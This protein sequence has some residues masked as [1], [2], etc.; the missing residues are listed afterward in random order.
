MKLFDINL[1]PPYFTD[2]QIDDS[3]Q[4]ANVLKLN[5][6]ELPKL[7][8]QYALTGDSK[9]II[10][11]LAARFDLT[12]I[13]YT[14]GPEGAMLYHQGEVSQCASKP[15]DIVDTVGAGDA[16]TAAMVLGIVAG[17]GLDEVNR[18]AIEIPS[19]VC[20]QPG[21]TMAFPADFLF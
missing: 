7:A 2:D 18:R 1:R 13:A 11:Q 14:R 10:G 15:V 4:L 8:T 20:G 3:L 12:T 17:D 21:A 16:F 6:D 5:E 9:E 19:Y